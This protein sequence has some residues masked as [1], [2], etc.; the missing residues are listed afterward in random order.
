MSD[1]HTPPPSP[2]PTP[3]SKP[4]RADELYKWYD[5]FIRDLHAY[6]KE[7]FANHRSTILEMREHAKSL[8]SRLAEAEA[9]ADKWAGLAA[10]AANETARL[11]KEREGAVERANT[12]EDRFRH[13]HVGP[14]DTCAEC[15]FDIR[16]TIH[17]N[18]WAARAARSGEGATDGSR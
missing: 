16:N 13:I 9:K 4:S 7:F 6:D 10:V 14:D 11:E 15:G 1:I 5:I 3:E 18:M 12:L 17:M 2:D 8:E